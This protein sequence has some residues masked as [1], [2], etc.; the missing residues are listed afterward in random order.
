ML[1]VQLVFTSTEWAKQIFLCMFLTQLINAYSV[2]FDN[3]TSEERTVEVDMNTAL[4]SC[5]P[6][7]FFAH[8]YSAISFYIIDSYTKLLL[9]FSSCANNTTDGILPIY[10]FFLNILHWLRLA[11]SLS[12]V[13]VAF[14]IML[15]CEYEV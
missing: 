2:K 9:L 3:Q 4:Y 15:E 6:S 12:E 1:S 7:L 14:R 5:C 11:V 13:S 8:F 10:L